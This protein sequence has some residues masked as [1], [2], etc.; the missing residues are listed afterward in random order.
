[1]RLFVQMY[2][3]GERAGL[4]LGVLY[5]SRGRRLGGGDMQLKEFLCVRCGTQ[6]D[7]SRLREPTDPTVCFYRN[8]NRYTRLV[9]ATVL[10]DPCAEALTLVLY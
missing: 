1:V 2:F 7:T 3:G 9:R 10:C 5:L 4:C 6:Q 8:G